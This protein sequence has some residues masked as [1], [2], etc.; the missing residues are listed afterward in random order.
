MA[1]RLNGQLILPLL[2]IILLCFP[3]LRVMNFW[4]MKKQGWKPEK[5]Y[6]DIECF[7]NTGMGVYISIF[8][9][10]AAFAI[11][12]QIIWLVIVGLVGVYRLHYHSFF[13]DEMEYVLPAAEVAKIENTYKNRSENENE[14]EKE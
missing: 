2:S 8:A 4:D 10:L 3:P 5:K 11:V 13:D 14:N 6:K 1:G 12:W 9:F 7:K